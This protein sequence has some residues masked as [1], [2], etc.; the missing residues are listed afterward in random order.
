MDIDLERQ[1]LG[2]VAGIDEVGRGPLAG[3]VVA[4]AVIADLE[5]LDPYFLKHVKDSKKLTAK[6]RE[7]LFDKFYDGG[8]WIGVGRVS[9][10]EIDE[11]NIL[12]ATFLAMERAVEA[13]EITSDYLLIDGNQIPKSMRGKAEAIVKG[14][15]HCFSIAAASI[16]AKVTRDRE[17]AKL[18]LEYPGFGWERNSGYGTAL[19]RKALLS[20]GITPHHRRSFEPVKSMVKKQAA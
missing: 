4:A 7:L 6:K 9:V 8:F 19:H 20:Q 3:P 10:E 12:N 14:D 13:L 2:R 17:M 1:Y 11:I 15:Q 5:P 18:A 16:I